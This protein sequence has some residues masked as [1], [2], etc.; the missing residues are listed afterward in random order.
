MNRKKRTPSPRAFDDPSLPDRESQQA[1]GGSSFQQT[2]P[3]S[4]VFSSLPLQQTVLENYKER[5]EGFL[6]YLL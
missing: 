4:D 3:V 5:G 1:F 6:L 2:Q